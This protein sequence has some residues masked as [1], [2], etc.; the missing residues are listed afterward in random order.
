MR[1]FRDVF[2]KVFLSVPR[3]FFVN[4]RNV[5]CRSYYVFFFFLII[6]IGKTFV[7]CAVHSI[8]YKWDKK[9]RLESSR[10][11]ASA[12]FKA[13]CQVHLQHPTSHQSCARLLMG[14][15]GQAGGQGEV[16]RRFAGVGGSQ[17]VR[18]RFAG[19]GGSWEVHGRGRFAGGL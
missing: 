18:G 2:L 13:L 14:C 3:C 11:D 16:C 4:F 5:L 7:C 19:A 17:E 15:D 9:R 10:D 6:F 8:I 12:R 1:Y